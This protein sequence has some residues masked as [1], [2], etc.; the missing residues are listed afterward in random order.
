MFG[1]DPAA[2]VFID[3]LPPNVGGRAQLRLARDPPPATRMRR[4]LELRA[5]GVRL[6]RSST[7]EA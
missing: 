5:L 1:L 3:D 2:T 4:A 7:Q 6:P